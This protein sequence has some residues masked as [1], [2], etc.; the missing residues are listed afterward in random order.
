MALLTETTDSEGF[1]RKSDPAKRRNA[2]EDQVM[3]DHID[4][5]KVR[6][7]KE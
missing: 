7:S 5:Y 1:R 4:Q 3:N 6:Y 2:D